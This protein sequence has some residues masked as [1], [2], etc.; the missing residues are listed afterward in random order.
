M[1]FGCAFMVR[2]VIVRMGGGPQYQLVLVET[3]RSFL[4][5]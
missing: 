4:L 5:S 3:H 1:E 2:E